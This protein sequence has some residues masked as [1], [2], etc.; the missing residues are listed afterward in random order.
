VK[1]NNRSMVTGHERRMEE[2]DEGSPM[3]ELQRSGQRPIVPECADSVVVFC[4]DAQQVSEGFALALEVMEVNADSLVMAA[5]EV[6][7][8]DRTGA[9]DRGRTPEAYRLS[10]AAAGLGDGEIASSTKGRA[11]LDQ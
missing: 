7:E 6:W 5:E 1:E 9:C 2:L 8:R 3:T 10:V 11:S 4:G